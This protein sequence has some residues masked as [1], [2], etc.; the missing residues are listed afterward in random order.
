MNAKPRTISEAV[1]QLKTWM[2]P[3]QLSVF[4][5]QPEEEL[6]D[7]HFG[8]GASIRNEFGLRDRDSPLLRDCTAS[9]DIDGGCIDP[10]D[11][12]MLI[13]RALWVRL[14]H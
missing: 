13:L 5:A 10:D 3:D 12:S 7:H 4:A 14:R 1:E 8:L 9:E 2:T 6:I 11:A